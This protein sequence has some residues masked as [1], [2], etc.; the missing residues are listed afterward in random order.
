MIFLSENSDDIQIT[1]FIYMRELMKN[2]FTAIK[3]CNWY[4]KISASHKLNIIGLHEYCKA[5]VL[6]FS[7]HFVIFG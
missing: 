5:L 1:Y 4:D 7:K 2:L 3:T 6:P